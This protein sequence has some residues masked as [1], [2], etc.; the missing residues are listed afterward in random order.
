V[1]ATQKL[2]IAKIPPEGGG[3]IIFLIFS[4]EDPP[5]STEEL[6]KGA[7]RFILSRMVF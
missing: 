7:D 6:K 3:D 1:L 4:G 5:H 2:K